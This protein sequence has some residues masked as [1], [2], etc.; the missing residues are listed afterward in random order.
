[1]GVLVLDPGT[2]ASEQPQQGGLLATSVAKG[3]VTAGGFT[4]ERAS[5]VSPNSAEARLEGRFWILL[6]SFKQVA[7]EFQP[8][9]DPVVWLPGGKVPRLM[10]S[11]GSNRSALFRTLLPDCPMSEFAAQRCSG[12]NCFE[13]G[14]FFVALSRR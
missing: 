7:G 1:M 9:D 10:T 13:M 5:M 12:A 4:K 2:Q 3:F 14:R 11:W 8:L 6:S